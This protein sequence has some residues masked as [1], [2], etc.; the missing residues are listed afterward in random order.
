MTEDVC[1]IC[2]RT[3]EEFQEEFDR[4]VEIVEHNGMLK[5]ERCVSEFNTGAGDEST[6][7]SHEPAPESRDWKD[8]VLA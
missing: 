3:S 5:C 8:E 6:E 4:E 2:G 7:E 1:Q